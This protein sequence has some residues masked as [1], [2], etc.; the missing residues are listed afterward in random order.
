MNIK[1]TWDLAETV[2]QTVEDLSNTLCE[3][4]CKYTAKFEE[5]HGYSPFEGGEESENFYSNHCDKC[6]FY[7]SF[8]SSIDSDPYTLIGKEKP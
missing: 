1:N 4:Y 8:G 3:D 7:W 6:P 5:E 2:M